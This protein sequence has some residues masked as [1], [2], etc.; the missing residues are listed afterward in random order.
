[1]ASKAFPWTVLTTIS[2]LIVW[3]IKTNF[4]R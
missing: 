4:K 3:A 2:G 1:M